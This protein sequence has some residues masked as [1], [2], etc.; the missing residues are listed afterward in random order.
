MIFDVSGCSS[1][2]TT[3]EIGT[4]RGI[5]GLAARLVSRC[6]GVGARLA[7]GR[8]TGFARVG[9]FP[10]VTGFAPAGGFP[11]VTGIAPVT[12]FAPLGG[13]TPPGGFVGAVVSFAGGP[14]LT[15]GTREE[16]GETTAK[17]L[18]PRV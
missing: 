4:G 12:G 7:P 6:A 11:P 10:P 9:G 2:I 8:V 3:S 15:I 18:T 14:A 1:L 16:S 5:T 13:L 17:L